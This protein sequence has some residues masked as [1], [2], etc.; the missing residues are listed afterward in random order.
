M[1]FGTV[2]DHF[3]PFWTIL[4]H[5]GPFWTVLDHFSH[6]GPSGSIWWK[7]TKMVQN[8]PKWSKMVPNGPKWS[9]TVKNSSKQS[10]LVQNGL[11][12]VPNS[13]KRKCASYPLIWCTVPP[14]RPS[15]RKCK[16]KCHLVSGSSKVHQSD[17]QTC[18]PDATDTLHT[19]FT[20][21]N[22]L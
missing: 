7:R 10:L 8:C 16:L 13:H 2:W 6:F 21:L 14:W 5:F 12:V 20:H 9:Q 22:C 1:P 15:W 18:K 4:D 11:N 17:V 3:G 19:K